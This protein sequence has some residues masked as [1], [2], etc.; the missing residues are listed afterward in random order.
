MDYRKLAEKVVAEIAKVPDW[1]SDEVRI[2]AAA[3]VLRSALLPTW[4]ATP[5]PLPEGA[6]YGVYQYGTAIDDDIVVGGADVVKA[7][8]AWSRYNA[9]TESSTSLLSV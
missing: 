7:G 9:Y 4:T 6:A 8:D 2:T 1:L 5:E 3:E